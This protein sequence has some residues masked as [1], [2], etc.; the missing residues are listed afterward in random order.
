MPHGVFHGALRRTRRSEPRKAPSST[1]DDP[2]LQKRK[3]S[4]LRSFAY[5]VRV[6]APPVRCFCTLRAFHLRPG[7]SR[8]SLERCVCR[9]QGRSDLAFGVEAFD[10]RQLVVLEWKNLPHE[11]T[12]FGDEV[13]CPHRDL[14]LARPHPRAQHWDELS[15]DRH[16]IAA[17]GIDPDGTPVLP[18]EAAVDDEGKPELLL[19]DII[20]TEELA[21]VE[22]V[23]ARVAR[24]QGGELARSELVEF[25]DCDASR[26]R[27]AERP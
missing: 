18:I 27:R 2:R 25:E 22:D 10:E 16:R 3:T 19:V 21:R 1:D 4:H 9:E 5:S 17:D 15:F 13:V 20:A 8:M 26:H 23:A 6:P 7:Y 11:S 24:A 12:R 14:T